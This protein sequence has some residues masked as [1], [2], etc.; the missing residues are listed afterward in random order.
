MGLIMFECINF[1][2]AAILAGFLGATEVSAMSINLQ[3]SFLCF[4][5]PLGVGISGNI[6]IGMFL[7]QNLAQK[8]F[9]TVKVVFCVACK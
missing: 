5:V 8:A 7:G 1:Q 9:E 6:R 3:M 2:L 4:L